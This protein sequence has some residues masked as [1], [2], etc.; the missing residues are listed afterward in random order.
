MS[1]AKEEIQEEAAPVSRRENGRLIIDSPLPDK[2]GTI[3]VDLYLDPNTIMNVF[4]RVDNLPEFYNQE[5]LW[6]FREFYSRFPIFQFK[7]PGLDPATWDLETGK[8]FPALL[9][10]RCVQETNGLINGALDLKN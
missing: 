1:K 2:P 5:S 9:A 10:V 4:K 6:V 8:G 3:E 7:I